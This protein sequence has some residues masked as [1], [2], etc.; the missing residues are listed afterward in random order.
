MLGF[1]VIDAILFGGPLIYY[2]GTILNSNALAEKYNKEGVRLQG[3][4]I[5][6]WI[7]MT[8]KNNDRPT[9]H[10]CL[11]YRV[12][13]DRYVLKNDMVVNQDLYSQQSLDLVRLPGY[14]KSAILLAS[15]GDMMDPDFPPSKL[16][17]VLCA[18]SWTT[19]FNIYLFLI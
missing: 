11:G 8:G 2:R 7:R 17:S 13:Q 9:F 15:I 16:G 1:G 4:V 10:I 6:R 5:A 12:D 3:K 19:L 14:R 18:F